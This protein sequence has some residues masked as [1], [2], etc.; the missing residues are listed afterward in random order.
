MSDRTGVVRFELAIVLTVVSVLAA[1]SPASGQSMA[2]GGNSGGPRVE[3]D[4]YMGDYEGKWLSTEKKVYQQNPTFGAQVIARGKGRYQINM[5]LELGHRTPPLAILEGTERR[6]QVVFD[7]DGWSGKMKDGT[8]TGSGFLKK[9]EMCPFEM[10]LVRRMSP[11]LGAKPPKG[12]IVLF[13]GSSFAGWEPTG[14]KVKKINWELVDGAMR[15]LSEKGKPRHCLQT[16]RRF[17]DCKLH[18]EFMLPFE[19]ENTG[20]G[21]GNSGVFVG[22]FEVQVLDS[23]GLEGYYNEC[24]ALYKLAA[25]KVNMCAPPLQWQTYDIDFTSARFDNN[26]NK[27]SNPRITVSHNGVLIHNDQE[28]YHR[29]SHAKTARYNPFSSEPGRISMQNHGHPVAFRNI[30]VVEK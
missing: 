24:G 16:K 26:G 3:S 18:I 25:P 17:R 13:D 4:P 21:R 23:Y 8:I 28:I 11:T 14:G 10:K 20:Q 19:P 1:A 2:F 6:G 9:G 22:Q 15:V 30:W 27:K 5:L 12:A 7:Q 29:T